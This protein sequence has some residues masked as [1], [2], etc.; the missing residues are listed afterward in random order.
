MKLHLFSNASKNIFTGHGAGY[1]K[2]ND[3]HFEQAI[4]VTPEQVFQDWTAQRFETLAEADFNYFLALQPD[5]L[6]IG[7]GSQHRF[8][9]P[10]LYRALTD[11]GIGVEFMDT[12][13]ACRT[14]NILVAEA[15]K[16]FAA[17]LL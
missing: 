10:Q 3:Q 7:T 12:A 8:A 14:C 16:V 17:I 15:R 4:V 9:H 11:A 6:L 2:V 13:A 1:V 5:V